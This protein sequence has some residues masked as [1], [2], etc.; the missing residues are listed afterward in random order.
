MINKIL[1]VKPTAWL[2]L[3]MIFL[4]STGLGLTRSMNLAP[5]N[6]LTY[7]VQPVIALFLFALAFWHMRGHKDR[8]RKKVDKAYIV[9]AIFAIWFVFYMASG[10]VTTYVH[11]ALVNDIRGVTLNLIAFVTTAA[12]LEYV[13][14]ATIS[15]AG[16]GNFAWYGVLVT[17]VFGLMQLGILGVLSADSLEGGI[18][19]LVSD[20]IPV[21]ATSALLTYM[22]VTA[23]I[24]SMMIYRLGN[25]LLMILPPFIPKHDWY[26]QGITSVVLA[27]AL[28]LAIDSTRQDKKRHLTRRH[29]NHAPDVIFIVVL[30]VMALFMIGA[31]A[32]KPIAIMS[33][34]MKPVF[35][36]GSVVIT[37]KITSSMDIRVGDIIQ[38]EAE[39]KMVT[40]RVVAISVARDKDGGRVFMTKGDNSPSVDEPVSENQLYGVVRYHIP[41]IGYPTVWL[42]ELSR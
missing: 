36:K 1:S 10:L 34:S 33:D 19:L 15:L 39:E 7:I 22:A 25:V 24:M 12:C 23:G 11:N 35:S 42:K 29:I 8:I 37:E 4:F 9:G 32:Y 16:R 14:Y 21:F 40:H 27:L 5:D 26:M 38:Y 2:L 6:T 18:K 3:V 30:A 31:F 41:F 20:I 13:R 28:Y 17:I